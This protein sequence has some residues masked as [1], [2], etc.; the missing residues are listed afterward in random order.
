MVQS[1]STVGTEPA[2]KVVT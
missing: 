2:V 1:H